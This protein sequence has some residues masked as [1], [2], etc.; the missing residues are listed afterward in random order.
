MWKVYVLALIMAAPM[1]IMA[2]GLVPC[3]GPGEEACQSCHAVLLISTVTNYLVVILGT[4]AA[5]MIMVS[6]LR[7]VVSV[8]DASAKAK[9]KS[10]ISSLLIGYVI[11]LAGWMIVDLGLKTLLTNNNYGVWNVV[12]CTAQP[13]A[14]AWSRPTASGDSATTLPPSAVSTR[15]AA[16]TSSGSLQNDIANAAAAAG[17]TNPSQVNTLRALISQESSNCQNRVGPATASG[18]AYGC[19]QMLVST[20]RTLDSSLAGLSDADVAARLENDNAYNLTLS[21]RYY[22]QLLNRYSSEPNQTQLALAAYNGGPGANQP[23]RDCP[24]QRRWQCVWDSPGCYG[25]G[26]TNCTPNA[27]PNSYAQTRNYVSN[28][29]NIASGL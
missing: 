2:A 8:G 17:I 21:A 14:M 27:G 7:L 9:A 6:G 18:V 26:Q 4:I 10:M 20:A 5:I 24:G 25:T 15:V 19:G 11:V 23:S 12:Q 22:N 28:I 1:L 3:G 29:T 16:I 13:T